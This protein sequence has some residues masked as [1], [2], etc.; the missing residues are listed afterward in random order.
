MNKIKNFFS[1]HWVTIL[2]ISLIFILGLG[3]RAHILRYDYMFEFDP[4]WHLRATGYVVQGNL[5]TNDPLG[6]YLQTESIQTYKYKYSFLWML[7]AAIYTITTF[8]AAYDKWLLM[9]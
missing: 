5:P 3:I 2:L 7:T 4:Y 8:G 1:K 9:E 6:F